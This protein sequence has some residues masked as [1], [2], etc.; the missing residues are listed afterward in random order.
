MG[1]GDK[2]T[3]KGKISMGSHGNS[4]PRNAAKSA[5][6]VTPKKE[7]AEAAPKA[8]KKAP[9]KKAAAKKA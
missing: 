8:E 7:K 6:A 1:K 3:K 4:R 9:A 2:K 5:V